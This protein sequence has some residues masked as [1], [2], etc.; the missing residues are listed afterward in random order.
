MAS[1]GNQNAS[2]QA[3]DSAFPN[4]PSDSI[5]CL[6]VNG[7]RQTPTTVVSAGSWDK[8]LSIYEITYNGAN[9]GNV[10]HRGAIQHD[11]PVLSADFMSDQQTVFSGGADGTVRMWNCTQGPQAL[12]T[13][14]KHD[15][16]VR[17]VKW[18]PELNVVASGSW[19]KTLR[20]W[21]CRQ[22]TPAMTV[23]TAE[24]IYAM[25]A[26]G[27][28]VVLGTADQHLHAWPDISQQ[29][30]KFEYKSP[31]NYQT[32]CV[33]IFADQQG[34]A[35]G[36]IE[37]RVAIEY[38]SECANKPQNSQ[39]FVFKC[40]RDGNDIY[41]VNAID[42]HTTNKFLT[43]GSDGTIVWWDKD[44]RNRLAIRDRFKKEAPIVAAKFSP[45]GQS[46]FYAA[47]Y[48]W[49]KGADAAPQCQTNTI[50]HHA[51]KESDIATRKS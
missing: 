16:A 32:R 35:V 42:F 46:M 9:L 23:Q 8:S 39:S 17:C 51:V 5:S 6:A 33:S 11:G 40:H 37:G 10:V 20:L 50:M 36:S 48:D 28:V 3:A 22:P 19:D 13:I 1:F 15:Q 27:K 31:L 43:A 29:Q 45:N 44:K 7:T 21:D 47:S 38:F 14:G 4:I 41:G 12:Q 2:P 34:F 18:I 25:D 49:G 30:S 26:A 24:R